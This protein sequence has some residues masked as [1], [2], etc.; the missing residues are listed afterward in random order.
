MIDY[1]AMRIRSIL[2]A[3]ALILK[4][5]TGAEFATGASTLPSKG[6]V[7][8]QASRIEEAARLLADRAA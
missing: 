7:R 1:R 2:I 6:V 3:S 8:S 4:V 5:P